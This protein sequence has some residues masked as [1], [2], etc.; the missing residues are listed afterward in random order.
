MSKRGSSVDQIYAD[1]LFGKFKNNPAVNRE[2]IIERMYQRI[3]TELAINRFKWT[4]LPP[5]VDVRFLE[6]TLFYSALSV[7]YF[8]KRYDKYFALRGGGTNWLNMMD[9]PVGF[10]V[11]GNNFIGQNLSALKDTE[12]GRK[13][14]PIWANYMRIPDLD[15]VQVYANRLANF[16]RTIEINSNNARRPKVIA[17]SESQRLSYRNIN[18]QIDEG[19]PVLEVNGRIEDMGFIQALDL[20]IDTDAIEKLHIVRTREWNECMGLLGIDN[21]NQDKKERLV[22]D[23]VDANN[24]QT[25]SMRFVNLNARRMACELINDYYG[26]NVSVEYYTDKER[27]EQME[28]ATSDDDEADENEDLEN[29]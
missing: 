13:A 29:E 7:F 4:G 22:S 1:F 24:E 10:S 18:R 25:S 12:N 9:N 26:L 21:A 14:I 17:A 5:E 27:R 19:Q 11:V 23:E 15:I 8:D 6:I 2:T 16:D 28:L 3:L 20:G